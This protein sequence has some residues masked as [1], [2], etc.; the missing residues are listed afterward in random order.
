M[1]RVAI[2]EDE[3]NAKNR[4]IACLDELSK[5]KGLELHISH[6]PSGS[7]FVEAFSCQFDIVFMDIETP[8]INGMDAARIMRK[9]DPEVILIFVTNLAQMA[10]E[11]YAVDAMDF[12]VKPVEPDHFLMKMER[13]L[14]RCQSLIGKSISL[15]VGDNEMVVIATKDILYAETDG[16][17]VLVHTP[18]GVTKVYSTLKDV[19]AKIGDGLTFVR[20]NRSYLVNLQYLERIEKDMAIVRGEALPISRPSHK[21]F[22][23]ALARYL[24]G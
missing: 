10:L 9:K 6:F 8:G 22:M 13:V 14:S 24:G 19:E 3:D 20:C 21:A 15:T 7:A 23:M 17:Y 18:K 1:I 2:V 16:H 4:L 12:I 5:R 11:G